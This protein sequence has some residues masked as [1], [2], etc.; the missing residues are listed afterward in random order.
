MSKPNWIHIRQ[1]IRRLTKWDGFWWIAGIVIVLLIGGILSWCFWEDLNDG[2]D[3]LSTMIRNLGLVI[4]GVIA[5][6]L[7]VWRSRIGE[8]QADAA[9]QQAEITRSQVEIAQSQIEIAR[10]QAQTAQ[11]SLL[12]ERYQRGA[13]MLGSSVLAVRIGGIYALARLAKD[14]PEQYHVQTMKVFCN[15]VRLPTNDN[16]INSHSNNDEGQDEQIRV[17][18]ADVQEVMQAIGSR[19]LIGIS[20]EQSEKV[21]LYLRDADISHLQVRSANLSGAWLTNANLSGAVLP[22]A[23]LSS[24]RLRSANLS[25]ARLRC[26]DLS[27]GKFWGADLSKAILRRANLSGADLCGADARSPLYKAPVRGL[28]QAQLDVARADPNNPPKLRGVLD[29]ETGKPL[30]WRGAAINRSP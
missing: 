24:A 25:N 17:L 2:K 18:R 7:A 16:G 13:E 1:F 30:V 26:A 12:N 8:R 19:S 22:Y 10:S 29:A 27:N 23:N 4:G 5:V 15:F 20:L 6:L 21:R 11:Q 28:T 9:Q 3:S 14:H